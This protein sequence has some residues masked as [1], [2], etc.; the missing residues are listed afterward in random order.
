MNRIRRLLGEYAACLRSMR[1]NKR[2]Q[3]VVLA[4]FKNESH[5]LAEWVQHYIT[6]GAI[7]VQLI[8]NN[9]N[10]DLKHFRDIH[11]PGNR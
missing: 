5:A 3:L 1:P 10:N 4:M 11:P 2:H 9:S 7:S 8:I 6:E